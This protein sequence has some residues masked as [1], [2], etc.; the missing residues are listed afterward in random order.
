MKLLDLEIINRNVNIVPSELGIVSH[1][2]N[3]RN[4]KTEFE[5][6]LDYLLS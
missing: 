4:R 5:A 3:I 1:G 2:Y 6:S